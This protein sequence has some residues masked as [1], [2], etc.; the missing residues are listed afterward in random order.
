M[1]A[2]TPGGNKFEVDLPGGGRL[3]LQ[4]AEEQD[5]W[6]STARDY[7]DEYDFLKP[8]DKVLL[9]MVLTQQVLMFRAQQKMNGMIP[10][11]DMA[12]IPTGQYEYK[13]PKSSDI[14]A[15]QGQITKASEE[16]RKIE[17][18]L[19]ID[20]KTR[21]AGGTHTVANYIEN[22]KLAAGQ[23]GVH[24]AKRTVAFEQFAMD[25]RWRIRL[26]R[27]GDEEDR[28]YHGISHEKIIDWAETELA[29]L[30]EVDK[31][32]AHERGK[33]WLGKL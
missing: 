25:L 26:L 28:H 19:G 30:E 14:T 32:Y 16:I 9:G 3:A 4:S 7:Q 8:N 5:M 13:E 1:A 21:E 23:Y 27:N 24:V 22:L 20:K 2:R 31:Q 12:G 6:E 17:A 33:L 15:Y 18:A 11:L 29:G 10:K